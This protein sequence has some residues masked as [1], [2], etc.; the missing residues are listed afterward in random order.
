[1]REFSA[2]T[3]RPDTI[4][5][6]SDATLTSARQA[7]D[8]G[9]AGTSHKNCKG[10]IKGIANAAMLEHRRRNDRGRRYELSAEDLTNV[11]PVALIQDLCVVAN[12]GIPH[13]ERNGHHYFKGLSMFPAN[14]QEAVLAAHPDVYH[15]KNGEI[16]VHIQSGILQ[17]GSIVDHAFGVAADFDPMQFTPSSQWTYESLM[18]G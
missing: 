17:V 14:V 6:E 5:D 12:L 7:V 9:Y 10:I 4:I 13:A 8:F 18:A 2:W 15:R 16:A 3:A 1:M 11:G